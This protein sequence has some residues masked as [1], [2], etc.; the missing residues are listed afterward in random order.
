MAQMRLI[1]HCEIFDTTPD[2]STLLSLAYMQ[3][4]RVLHFGGSRRGCRAI[5]ASAGL[6]QSVS[7]G[8][9]EAAGAT[10]ISPG[11]AETAARGR[12]RSTEPPPP[13]ETPADDDDLS[14]AG[15]ATDR[16]KESAKYIE[17]RGY[18]DDYIGPFLVVFFPPPNRAWLLVV[19]WAHSMAP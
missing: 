8:D 9:E 15:D 12:R 11:D 4:C 5:S 16:E 19:Y 13:L 1:W 3:K 17:K 2:R 10:A 18:I 6:L 14:T 7:E